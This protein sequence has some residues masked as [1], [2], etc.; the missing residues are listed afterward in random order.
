MGV[1]ED[2]GLVRLQEPGGFSPQPIN[3]EVPTPRVLGSEGSLLVGNDLSHLG[4]EWN[5]CLCGTHS[6]RQMQE[7]LW[8][9]APV[10][11]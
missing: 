8:C 9:S 5:R 6:P 1:E 4:D 10:T 7:K 2:I 3:S 11:K